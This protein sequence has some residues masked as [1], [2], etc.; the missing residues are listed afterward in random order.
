MKNAEKAAKE[1]ASNISSALGGINLSKITVD[2]LMGAGLL[3]KEEKIGFK[4]PLGS[5]VNEKV[6]KTASGRSFFKI[7]DGRYVN[8]DDIKG[9]NL[10]SKTLVIPKGTPIYTQPY[11][12]GTKSAKAGLANVDERGKELIVPKQGRYR[13]MEYGDAVVPHNLSQRLFDVATNPLK[14][15]A[16]AINS[17][18]SPILNEFGGNNNITTISIENITMPQSV[19]NA[20][21]FVKEL[22]LIAANR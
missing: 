7:A 8:M 11:A 5:L 16:N 13:M 22:Q 20:D 4:K 1:G 17:I 2:E 12:S 15:I 21:R 9:F 19:N 10:N 6:T 18:K 14:F 3:E